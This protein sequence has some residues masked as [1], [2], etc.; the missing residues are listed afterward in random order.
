MS[1]QD[2]SRLLQRSEV[3]ETLGVSRRTLDRLTKAGKLPVV[4]IDRRPRYLA[5]DVIE[6]VESR[7]KPSRDLRAAV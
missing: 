7:R 1:I 2:V 4:Y 3:A 6:F 5:E